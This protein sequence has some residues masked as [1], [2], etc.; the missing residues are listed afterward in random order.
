MNAGETSP[1]AVD[2]DRHMSS[3]RCPYRQRSLTVLSDKRLNGFNGIATW[4]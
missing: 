1:R 2:N 3:F 4:G